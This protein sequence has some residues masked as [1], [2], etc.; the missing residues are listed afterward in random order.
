MLGKISVL[1]SSFCFEL[2]FSFILSNVRFLLTPIFIVA[3]EALLVFVYV[4][5]AL[6]DAITSILT[7]IIEINKLKV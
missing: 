7:K 3:F 4:C 6:N 1:C 2:I 5:S